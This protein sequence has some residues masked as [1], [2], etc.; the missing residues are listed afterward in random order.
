MGGWKANESQARVNTHH[1]FKKPRSSILKAPHCASTIYSI[2]C[3][4]MRLTF[5][6]GAASFHCAITYQFI[7]VKI[8]VFLALLC[9]ECV[10][11][12]SQSC[13]ISSLSLS[14]SLFLSASAAFRRPERLPRRY[15]AQA[16]RVYVLVCQREREIQKEEVMGTRRRGSRSH[17]HWWCGRVTAPPPCKRESCPAVHRLYCT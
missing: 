17:L 11:G 9:T 6:T 15:K 13:Y 12:V 16:V 10:L 2:E 3:W 5:S 14:L 1:L 7:A 4:S 8:A